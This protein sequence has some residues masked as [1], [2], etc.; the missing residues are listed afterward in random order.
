MSTA[1]SIYRDL[2]YLDTTETNLRNSRLYSREDVFFSN[3]SHIVPKRSEVYFELQV[4]KNQSCCLLLINKL[5][6]LDAERAI[7]FLDY[8]TISYK[9]IKYIAT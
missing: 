7:Q 1:N 3:M 9:W 4:R 8:I 2:L 6:T 5:A